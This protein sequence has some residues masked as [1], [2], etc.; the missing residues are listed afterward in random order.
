MQK[1]AGL[2]WTLLKHTRIHAHRVK[3]RKERKRERERERYRSCTVM[4][5]PSIACNQC[6]VYIVKF[7]HCRIL[8]FHRLGAI[9]QKFQIVILCLLIFLLELDVSSLQARVLL[10]KVPDPL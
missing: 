7:V 6:N 8:M 4:C 1:S 2:R 5:P 9:L 3:E 10:N